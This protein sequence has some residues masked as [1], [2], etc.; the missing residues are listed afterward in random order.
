MKKILLLALFYFPLSGFSQIDTASTSFP[1]KDN[2]VVYE[3]ILESKDTK[4]SEI[5]VAAKKWISDRFTSTKSVIQSEDAS[6]GQIIGKGKSI[7]WSIGTNGKQ[8]LGYELSFSI[9]ID[10]KD[11]KFRIRFYDIQKNNMAVGVIPADSMDILHFQS[12]QLKKK[13]NEK[14][15]RLVKYTNNYFYSMAIDFANTVYKSKSDTF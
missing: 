4:Q 2:K 7:I 5:Y 8:E 13:N 1:I 14:W 6:Y 10:A 11:N 12:A 9:Q 3:L 15:Y